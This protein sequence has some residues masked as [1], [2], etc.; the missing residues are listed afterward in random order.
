MI[1]L[2][3]SESKL[4]SVW[5]RIPPAPFAALPAGFFDARDLALVSELSEADSAD[6]VFSEVS[7][8]S[9]ADLASVIC[10]RREL[11]RTLLLDF[12]GSFCHCMLLLTSRKA[13]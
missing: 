9:S 11:C 12:H 4:S 3:P 7:M 6:A 8:W 10:S 2:H 1:R 5:I 13:C